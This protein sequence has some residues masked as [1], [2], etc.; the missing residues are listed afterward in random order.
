[1]GWEPSFCRS[2]PLAGAR[3][4]FHG[5]R[6]HPLAQTGGFW[7]CGA[8]SAGSNFRGI[9]RRSE[10]CAA[11]LWHFYPAFPKRV[12]QT[13]GPQRF[14][15]FLIVFTQ[16]QLVPREKFGLDEMTLCPGKPFPS[17][18]FWVLYSLCSRL[19]ELSSPPP[20]PPL[21]SASALLSQC[22]LHKIVTC[23]FPEGAS[24]LLQRAV[25]GAGQSCS[26]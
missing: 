18:G 20:P 5:P 26:E 7:V 8:L 23:P 15:C 9:D 10:I 6:Q 1:M 12:L 3:L 11:V 17:A 2:H 13:P 4:C 21:P 25:S 19:S 22:L 14:L 24:G 16:H